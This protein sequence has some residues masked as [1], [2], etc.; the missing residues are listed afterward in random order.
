MSN[1]KKTLKTQQA[2]VLD[3]IWT[4]HGSNRLA[5]QMGFTR[6]LFNAWK[7]S[8]GHVP[9]MHLGQVSRVLKLDKYL[10]NYE[11]MVELMGEHKH[12]WKQLIIDSE[13]FDTKEME[14][15]FK[16]VPPC[17]KKLSVS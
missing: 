16:G 8:L 10:L 15:I 1:K 13:Y 6:S 2:R 17:T 4:K 7:R 12:S 9:L 3:V 5:V 14:Y 11:Q